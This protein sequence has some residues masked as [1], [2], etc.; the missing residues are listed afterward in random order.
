[1]SITVP[2]APTAAPLR[3]VLLQ[4]LAGYDQ[5]LDLTGALVDLGDASVAVVPLGG[6]VGHVTHPSQNLDGLI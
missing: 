2:K 1:M 6:H 4:Q 5:S 3:L